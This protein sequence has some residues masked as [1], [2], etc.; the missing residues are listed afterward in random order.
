M[1]FNPGKICSPDIIEAYFN[2]KQTLD[3]A[4]ICGE[5]DFIIYISVYSM[6][7]L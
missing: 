6:L 3:D 5:K 1:I 7:G 4:V 2:P